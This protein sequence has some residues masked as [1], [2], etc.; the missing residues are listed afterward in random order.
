MIN[1]LIR[2]LKS[3]GKILL[4][5]FNKQNASYVKKDQSNIATEIDLLSENNILTLIKAKFPS[6]S[7]LSEESGFCDNAS[8]YLWVVDPLDGTSNY[9]CRIPWFAINIAV[10]KNYQ[11][12]I[13]GIY[14][15]F[16]NL[17]YFA[18][19]GSR[20]MLNNKQIQVTKEKDLNKVLLAYSLD[21]SE[22]STKT[23]LESKIIKEL[24]K[25]VRNLRSTNSAIDLCYT[26]DGR[27]GG[28]LN[29]AE[30]IW[31]IAPASLIIQQA[32]GLITDIYG[33]PLDFTVNQ[34]NYLRN[35][36]H[37]A[38]SKQLHPKLLNLVR[39]ASMLK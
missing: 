26:A 35:F 3:S 23:A 18:I 5:H 37:L 8:D 25:N 28:C 32:G 15:P 14:L 2:A 11:V 1:I 31:D 30:M 24:V 22:N 19:K 12:I 36:T 27:F 39:K 38:S 7:I 20:S 16:Y 33:K 29:Q 6:H 21:Y 9:V 10:L 13:A 17:L 34:H 4:S